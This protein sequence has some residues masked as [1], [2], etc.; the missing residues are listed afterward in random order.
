EGEAGRNLHRAGRSRPPRRREDRPQ[1]PSRPHRDDRQSPAPH[2]GGRPRLRPPPDGRRSLPPHSYRPEQPPRRLRLRPRRPE[3]PRPERGLTLPPAPPNPFPTGLIGVMR[4]L[5]SGW[6]SIG[7]RFTRE[8]R[9][10][11]SAR[12]GMALALALSA[13]SSGRVAPA[14]EPSVA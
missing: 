6:Y 13:V 2:R 5:G 14:A 3:I 1:H 10:M 4:C 11:N 12:V 8:K 7:L 9:R